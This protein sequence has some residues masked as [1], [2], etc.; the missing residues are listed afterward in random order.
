MVEANRAYASGSE[1]ALH[2]LLEAGKLQDDVLVG[3]PELILLTRRVQEVK[4]LVL[5]HENEIEEITHSEMYRLQLRV[6]QADALGIDLF[7][8]L[9]MQVERQIKKARNRLEALQ[10]VMMTA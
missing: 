8:D 2:S 4:A 3:S 5:E 7:A 6:A 10:G 1:E 9:L